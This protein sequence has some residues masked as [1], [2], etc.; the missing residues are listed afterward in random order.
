MANETRLL[1]S[2]N[3]GAPAYLSAVDTGTAGTWPS[4]TISARILAFK[5]ADENDPDLVGVNR[6]A[7][8]DWDNQAIPA[9]STIKI[10]FTKPTDYVHHYGFAYQAGATFDPAAAANLCTVVTTHTSHTVAM[11]A[12]ADDDDYAALTLGAAVT[13]LELFSTPASNRPRQNVGVGCDGVAYRKSWATDIENAALMLQLEGYTCATAG[14]YKKLR[15]WAQYCVSVKAADGDSNA[16]IAAY[17]GALAEPLGIDSEGMSK[18]WPAL[19]L[20][21]TDEDYN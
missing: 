11:V 7:V 13:S 12:V 3:N 16:R 9:L 1:I 20:L 8:G 5:N 18:D 14:Y 2:V 4:V 15:K 21:V 6:S 17:Y 19:T 10:A